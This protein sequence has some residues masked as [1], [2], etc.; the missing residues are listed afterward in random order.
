[1]VWGLANLWEEGKEGTYAVR[2]GDCPNSRDLGGEGMENETNFFEW[3]Y[4]CLFLYGKG[5]LEWQQDVHV[6]FADHIRW[7]LHYH[8]HW[9]Q[10]QCKTFQQDAWLLLSITVGKMQQA[11]EEE[12]CHI[13]I[14]DPAIH[15]LHQ[16]LHSTAGWVF[17]TDQSH[18]QLRS[19]IWVTSIMYNPPSL[20]IT[21]NPCDLHDPIA[22]VFVGEHIDMNHFDRTLSPAKDVHAQNVAGDP[23]A[24]VRI[25]HFMIRT[26]IQ[27]LFGITA[28]PHQVLHSKGVFGT[29]NAYFGVDALTM[30]EMEHLLKGEG[31]QE[32]ARRFIVA[33]IQAYLP[34]LENADGI[35][36]ICNKVDVAFS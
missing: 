2:H 36:Q 33:N 9:I 27:T 16:H 3:A 21:I 18:Y 34:G 15:L 13:P 20:W 30:D 17:G 35:S 1:M 8:D 14:S 7:T 31:F 26:I 29:V 25:F 6:D 4:P 12:E 28:T 22:Q 11:Q 32:W 23:Y 24:A 5:G 10:M 19:Q